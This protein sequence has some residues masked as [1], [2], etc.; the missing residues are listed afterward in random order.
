[1]TTRSKCL[2][3]CQCSGFYGPITGLRLHTSNSTPKMLLISCG[4]IMSNK[5]ILRSLR[6]LK[7]DLRQ[8]VASSIMYQRGYLAQRDLVS[9]QRTAGTHAIRARSG[10]SDGLPAPAACEIDQGGGQWKFKCN[11]SSFFS[12]VTTA[13]SSKSRRPCPRTVLLLSVFLPLLR[14][15]PPHR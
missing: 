2:T 7:L 4:V 3:R 1:M 9:A 15:P 8:H 5:A 11:G 14:Y 13:C 6:L 10:G 12:T